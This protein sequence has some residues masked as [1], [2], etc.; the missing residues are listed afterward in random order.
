MFTGGSQSMGLLGGSLQDHSRF[1]DFSRIIRINIVAVISAIHSCCPTAQS[2]QDTVGT[3]PGI[4][5]HQ[6]IRHRN[7]GQADTWELVLLVQVITSL[8]TSDCC[9]TH[10]ENP[11][12]VFLPSFERDKSADQQ[13][14]FLSR[15]TV[16][17]LST[18][19]SVVSQ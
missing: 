13:G 9:Y 6:R 1:S 2:R 17:I 3:C 10:F 19:C 7:I 11:R 8:N 15:S 14:K 18:Q 4:L 16:G 5:T 12:T